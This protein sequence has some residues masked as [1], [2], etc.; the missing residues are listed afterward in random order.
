MKLNKPKIKINKN[1]N[2]KNL[3]KNN[4]KSKEGYKS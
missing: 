4:E 2:S 1:N 3:K